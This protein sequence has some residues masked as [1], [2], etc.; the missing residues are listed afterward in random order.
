M[1]DTP[2]QI[3]KKINKYAFSGGQ[4]TTEEHQRL[5][6]NPDVDV[7]YQ[8]LLHLED[9]DAEMERL[10]VVRLRFS[11]VWTYVWRTD[12][13]T[14]VSCGTTADRRAQED[15]HRETA[16]RRWVV[17]GAKGESGRG[18]AEPLL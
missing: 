8:Y 12:E 13:R 11:T 4:T 9:D 16:G 14:G 18:G 17:P 6:G 3:K 2:A 5:G 1:N 10:A 7:A 15:L